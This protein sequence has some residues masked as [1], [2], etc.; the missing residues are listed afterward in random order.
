MIVRKKFNMPPNTAATALKV[1]EV[2]PPMILLIWR[3]IESKFRRSV[4]PATKGWDDKKL[5]L[6]MILVTLLVLKYE[7]RFLKKSVDSESNGKRRKKSM[8]MTQIAMTIYIKMTE[9]RRTTTIAFTIVPT[10]ILT[11][12]SP[13]SITP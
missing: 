9:K 2:I 3:I 4:M 7:G 13:S 12:F 10:L 1:L 11:V 8:P 6:D 5:L